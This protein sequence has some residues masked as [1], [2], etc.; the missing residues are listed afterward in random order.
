MIGSAATTICADN[1]NYFQF[2]LNGKGRSVGDRCP[3]CAAP[4]VRMAVSVWLV[5]FL[6]RVHRY[7]ARGSPAIRA[8]TGWRGH[9]ELAPRCSATQLGA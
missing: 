4:Q 1:H 2:K 7:T 6:G 3:C 9:R 5:F 8:G